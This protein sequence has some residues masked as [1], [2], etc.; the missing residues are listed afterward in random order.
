MS[1]ASTNISNTHH[2]HQCTASNLETPSK[3]FEHFSI[4]RKDVSDVIQ[5]KEEHKKEMGMSDKTECVSVHEKHHRSRGG[6]EMGI[7]RRV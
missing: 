5:D 6:Y 2:L 7:T 3:K 1:S 4:L